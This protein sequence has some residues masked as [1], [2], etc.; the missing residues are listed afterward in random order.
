MKHV[1]FY[2]DARLLKSIREEPPAPVYLIYGKETYY[3]GHCLEKLRQ[4]LIRKGTE[5]FNFRKYDGANLDMTA[6]RTDCESL[7]LMADYK[8]VLIRNPNLEKFSASDLGILEEILADPNPTT[9]LILYVSAYDLNPKKSAK[10]KKLID[11][12]AK[13]G[14]VTEVPIKTQA[15][16]SRLIRQKCQK[17][18]CSM[19]PVVASIL[20]DRCGS[21]M[22]TLMRET[23][24]LIAYRPEGEITRADVETVTHKSL[25]ASVYDIS[26]ALLGNGRM[27]VFQIL[28]D[29]LTQ[30]EEPM[31][32]LSVLSS[33]FIDLYRAKAAHNAGMTADDLLEHFRYGSRKFVIQNAFRDVPK[34]SMGM[35][36][37][38]LAVLQRTELA[39]K[40]GGGNDRILLEE[41]MAQILALKEQG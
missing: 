11:S 40:S 21:A 41:A 34:Y 35:I 30:R 23:D 27:R 28:S 7:P 26:R 10:L 14:I 39:M 36:R 38:S 9:V 8:C 31:R 16:L 22:E 15:E 24:K 18:G 29:L 1:P 37:E 4:K 3:S 19:D 33:T 17:A 13:V 20:I 12:I 32:I 6:V 5:S 2:D 25:E